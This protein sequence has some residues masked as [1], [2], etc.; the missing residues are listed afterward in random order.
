MSHYD[1]WEGEQQALVRA[2]LSSDGYTAYSSWVT[3]NAVELVASYN[4]LNAYC[5]KVRAG[6]IGLQERTVE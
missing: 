6:S 5:R 3:D 2:E 1:D 4:K